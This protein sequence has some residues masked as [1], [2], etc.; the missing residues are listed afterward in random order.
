MFEDLSQAIPKDIDLNAVRSVVSKPESSEVLSL[1]A[2]TERKRSRSNLWSLF[3]GLVKKR[4]P[5][6]RVS[7]ERFL[8]FFK[9]LERLGVGELEDDERGRSVFSWR[10]RMGD[11]LTHALT[12]YEPKAFV[13][14]KQ[15]EEFRHLFPLRSGHLVTL[16]LPIDLTYEEAT[17][18]ANFVMTLPTSGPSAG[19]GVKPRR[20]KAS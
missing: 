8:E 11:F 12:P 14:L 16:K 1:L 7:Y 20:K 4:G 6:A 13:L 18:L 9:D 15:I 2:T 19:Q 10:W 3:E 17:R 5:I